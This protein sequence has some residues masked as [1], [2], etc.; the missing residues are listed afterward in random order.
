MAGFKISDLNNKNFLALSGNGI[1]AVLAVGQMALLTRS[2]SIPDFGMWCF[3]LMIYNLGDALRNGLL[4]TATIKFYAGTA[5]D[6][7]HEVLGSVWFLALV[8]TGVLVLLDAAFLPF[9]YLIR[10]SEVVMCIK[11]FGVTFISSLLFNL[12]F[13]VLM[14]EEKYGKILWIKLVN[15]G[16]MIIY[17]IVLMLLK[18]MSLESLLWCNFLTNCLA[19]IVGL[20]WG[21][22]KVGTIKRRSK[23]CIL[24]LAHFG[25]YSLGTTF[26]SRLFSSTDA[27]VITAM[28]GP[29]ALAIYSI[30]LKLMELVEFPLRSFV[31]TGMSGM[32]I[33]YNNNNVHQTTY[34]FRKYCGM[35][36]IAFIPL[37]VLAVVFSDLGI[38]LLFG[39]KYAGTE[40]AN[41]YRILM[42]LA[43]LYP[44]DRFIGATLDV[45][46]KPVLNFY[47]VIIMLIFAV[48]G[49]Y[50]GVAMLGNLYGVA[51]ASFFTMFSGV[52]FG[53]INLSKYLK[54]SLPD[55]LRTGYAEMKSF[56]QKI[57]LK[58]S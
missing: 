43:I 42:V 37:S 27:F 46:H 7:G 5:R 13:W 41:I 57:L 50:I 32:A 22:A 38:Q 45:I 9:T 30:P 19:S 4:G 56:L 44:F 54:V 1:T 51:F 35:L 55:V 31:G 58:A 17:I 14:A 20:V 21:L 28:L 8:V 47:K 2:L 15:S 34:I 26:V 12:I 52:I 39:N 36:T 3:F 16:S 11:W 10:S 49:D 33:A 18:K 29:A 23:E 48:C 6:R 24:E 40:A 25:K 53:Y